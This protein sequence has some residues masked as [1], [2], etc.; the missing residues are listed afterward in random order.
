MHK[1]ISTALLAAMTGATAC[2]TSDASRS[3]LQPDSV[4]Q[5]EVATATTAATTPATDGAAAA[6]TPVPDPTPAPP[7]RERVATRQTSA[8][9]VDRSVSRSPRP[10]R[11]SAGAARSTNPG[12]ARGSEPAGGT[13]IVI[14]TP[15]T[16]GRTSTA[17][18]TQTT[19]SVRTTSTVSSEVEREAPPPGGTSTLERRTVTVRHA[20]RD[21]AIGAAAG[22]IL[23][24]ATSRDR[25]KGAI[26]GGAA[27]AVAGGVYGHN[28]D[29]QRLDS[30]Q[31]LRPRTRRP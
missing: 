20:E 27:G 16:T 21:A 29:K 23:G 3:A 19:H 13:R 28:V 2:G 12:G 22:A 10:A 11:S 8:G 17:E 26:I 31:R 30:T 1:L 18:T 14:G 9:S 15:R 24:A 5:R 7:A 4:L 25:A 6:S